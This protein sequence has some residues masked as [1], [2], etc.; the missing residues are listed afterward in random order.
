MLFVYRLLWPS[1]AFTKG[2]RERRSEMRDEKWKRLTSRLSTGIMSSWHT[3][4]MGVWG[5]CMTMIDVRRLPAHSV[6]WTM[7]RV[8]GLQFFSRVLFRKWCPASYTH[9][10]PWRCSAADLLVSA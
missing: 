2:T 7:C 3:G 9:Q 8:Q 5:S 1:C 4:V 6:E 10:G